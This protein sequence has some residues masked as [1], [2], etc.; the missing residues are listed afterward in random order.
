[1]WITKRYKI[2]TY[3]NCQYNII[4]GIPIFVD[5]MDSIKP[6]TQDVKKSIK[7][8]KL[9]VKQIC[10]TIYICMKYSKG[11]I[12][13]CI[14][15]NTIIPQTTK[16]LLGV[17][18]LTSLLTIFQLNH[19]GQFYWWRKPEYTQKTTSLSQVTDNLY[20]IMLY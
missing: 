9:R 5:F 2:L 19:G 10:V 1:M 13:L 8:T 18:C 16:F 12:N 3:V 4:L 15:E 20:H 17:W 7:P 6:R 14:H 11:S